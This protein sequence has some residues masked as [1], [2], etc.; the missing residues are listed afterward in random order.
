MYPK[1]CVVVLWDNGEKNVYR[2]GYEKAYD[3]RIF[4]NAGIGN[5]AKQVTI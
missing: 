1:Q 5:V 2:A 4:D 3:L